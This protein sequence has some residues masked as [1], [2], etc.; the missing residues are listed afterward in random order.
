[1]ALFKSKKKQAA[2]LMESGLKGAGTVISVQDT[3][4]TVNDNPRVKM[5]FRVEP[6]DG[7]PPFD[8]QKTRTVS[9]VEIPRQGDRYPIWYDAE[10]PTGTWA[11]AT[12]ADDSGRESL[13]QM[14]GAVADTFVGMNAPAAPAPVS[15]GG[16]DVVEQIKQLADLH[17]QG[18][19]TDEEFAAQK[20]KL[21]G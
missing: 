17:Q 14:F 15:G 1:M 6:L 19:L 16:Q 12:V 13:R 20:A 21:L 18:I 9:R 5:V 7:S 11:Y 3:G 4:M 2:E 8:A 10:D